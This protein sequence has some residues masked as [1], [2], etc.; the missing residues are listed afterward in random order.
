MAKQMKRDNQSGTKAQKSRGKAAAGVRKN[1]KPETGPM[2]TVRKKEFM[3][4]VSDATGKTRAEVAAV[5]EA[6]LEQLGLAFGNGETLAL[7]PF[8]KARVS[9]Q[10]DIQGGEVLVL[11]LRRKVTDATAAGAPDEDDD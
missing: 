4:R 8:G 3:A 10:K 9:R 1:V 2:I 6:T 5:V 11:R 7:P